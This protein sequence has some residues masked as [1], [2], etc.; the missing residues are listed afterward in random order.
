M[1][2][3]ILLL[4]FCLSFLFIP[5]A[6]AAGH[7]GS[8]A[9]ATANA[10]AGAVAIGGGAGGWSVVNITS[11]DMEFLPN[12]P[13]FPIP[14]T[15]NTQVGLYNGPHNPTWNVRIPRAWEIQEI[16]T[17][18]MLTKEPAKGVVIEYKFFRN[19]ITLHCSGFEVI[20]RKCSIT[21][22]QRDYVIYARVTA[23]AVKENVS[24]DTLF[25]EVGK[26]NIKYVKTPS[27]IVA[28]YGHNN[29]DHGRGWNIGTG[30]GVS[31]A[32]GGAGRLLSSVGGGTGTGRTQSYSHSYGDVTILCMAPFWLLEELG[33]K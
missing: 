20:N 30:G 18:C 32:S 21:E 33:I 6:F 16:W 12:W 9:N 23:Y 14:V 27:V 7:G 28:V 15:P 10:N 11:G 13:G 8:K 3:K 19:P 24:L 2:T 17:E 4:G 1:K 5:T 26:F 22:L 25:D 29:K 31:I